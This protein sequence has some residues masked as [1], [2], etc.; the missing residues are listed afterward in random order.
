MCVCV[1]VCV[2]VCPHHVDQVGQDTLHLVDVDILHLHHPQRHQE[3][4]QRQ[5]VSPQQ[6]VPADRSQLRSP[7]CRQPLNVHQQGSNSNS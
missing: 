3:G 1:C 4:V 7:S 6:Q 5:L 2:C